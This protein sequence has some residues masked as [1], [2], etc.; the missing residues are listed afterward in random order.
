MPNTGNEDR[1]VTESL[2]QSSSQHVQTPTLDMCEFIIKQFKKHVYG[3]C[4]FTFN[5][6]KFYFIA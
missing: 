5:T 4:L 2:V 3:I 6:Y 1:H